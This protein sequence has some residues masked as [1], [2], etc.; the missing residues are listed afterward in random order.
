MGIPVT[1]VYSAC[2]MMIEQGYGYIFGTSGEEWTSTK[3]QRLESQHDE[4]DPNWGGS[5]KYG[6]KWIGHFV[7]DCSGAI[8]K[9][10]RDHGLKIPHGSSSMVRQGYIIDCGAEPHPGWAALVDPT[11]ETDDNKHIGIVMEDGQT[12]FEAKGASAGCVYSKVTDKKWT[13]FGKFKDVDYEGVKPLNTPYKAVVTTNS[14]SL[15]VRS[16]PGTEYPVI[17][18]LE[19]GATVT[20]VTHTGDWDYVNYGSLQGYCATRYLMPVEEPEP[21]PEPP[22]PPIENVTITVSKATAQ[23]WLKVLKEMTDALE[24]GVQK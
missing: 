12:V 24:G 18:K 14:G 2:R 6:R 15:N 4:D 19:K 3:Q 1:D 11:P 5:V 9:I 7:V 16:G 8:V 17:G 13:K 20:V 21:T 23:E 22:V 10:W